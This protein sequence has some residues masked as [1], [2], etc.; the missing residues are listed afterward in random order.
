MGAE[1][2]DGCFAD[3]RGPERCGRH[4]WDPFTQGWRANDELSRRSVKSLH[5]GRTTIVHFRGADRSVISERVLKPVLSR[6]TKVLDQGDGC[7]PSRS[8]CWSRPSR[9]LPS[10][11]TG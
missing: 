4:W 11:A 10:N 9:H 7:G 6:T 1:G 3:W 5:D 2:P 8:Q